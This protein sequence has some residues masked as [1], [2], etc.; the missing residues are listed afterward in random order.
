MDVSG[1]VA[2]PKRATCIHGGM[3]TL[4][5]KN[6]VPYVHL[7]G[8]LMEADQARVSVL[9]HGL[10]YGDGLFETVRV[11]NGH[12]FRPEA[13]LYRLEQ[14]AQ[15]LELQLPW[16]RDALLG[17]LQE[18]AAANRLQDG[19]LR[20]TVTRG[21]GNPVPD[22][23]TCAAPTYFIT[24]RST[25]PIS[26]EAFERGVQLC[27]GPQH[28]RFFVPG[29]KSLCFLPYQLARTA[30]RSRGCDDA[31]LLWED[32]V[33]E[34]GISNLFIV[35]A[36][37]LSTPDLSSGCLPGTTRALLLELAHESGVP[38]VEQ[39]ITLEQL[40]AADEV[41]ITNSVIG[42]LPVREI[43]GRRSYS[44]PGPV[45]QLFR[46]A[47]CERLQQETGHSRK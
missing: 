20:L 23:G 39:P 30:A 11:A 44:A 16:S 42:V 26:D 12:C 24:S 32:Q 19:A 14:S 25:E 35:Q 10:L 8:R 7:N 47:Y 13:H 15:R 40:A 46:R 9:D 21:E 1:F 37:A 27:L 18:T 33:V 6:A 34:T 36:N 31:V 45:T 3:L 29:L 38:V 28:P 4:A 43:D 2:T 22:P 5:S 41:L 17:A